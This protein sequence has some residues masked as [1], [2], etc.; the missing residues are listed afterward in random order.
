MKDNSVTLAGILLFGKKP[1]RYLPQAGIHAAAFPGIEKDYA[2]IE[3][4]QIQGA[5]TPLFGEDG[6]KIEHGLVEKA[7]SF[8]RRNTSTTAHLIDGS[9]RQDRPQYPEEAVRET[10]VNALIHRDYLLAS[11][12]IE[13]LIFKNRL[14][15]VSPGKLPDG[16]TPEK[17]RTGVRSPRNDLLRYVMGDYNY[18]EH[19]GMGVS[20]KIVK[21]MREHNQT[22]PELIEENERFTVRLFA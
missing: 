8:V 6:E 16:I 18:L 10:I 2:V 1:N 12:D 4:A 21:E 14:E 15:V 3:R 19:L 5:M 11:T 20:R 7:V 17:M 9:R 13:L 22:E